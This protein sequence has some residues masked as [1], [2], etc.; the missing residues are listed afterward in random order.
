MKLQKKIKSKEVKNP[1]AF[2]LDAIEGDYASNQIDYNSEFAP[3]I[4]EANKCW[5]NNKGGCGAIWDNYKDLKNHACYF[6]KKF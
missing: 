2:L 5:A 3:F 6:C 1:P 4:S